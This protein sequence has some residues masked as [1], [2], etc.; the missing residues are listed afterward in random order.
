MAA[1]RGRL[2]DGGLV[3]AEDAADPDVRVV[4]RR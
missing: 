3:A 4:I 2:V 1:S